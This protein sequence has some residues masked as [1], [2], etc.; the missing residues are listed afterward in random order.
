MPIA[1]WRI[2]ACAFEHKVVLRGDFGAP[3]ILDD[4]NLMRLDDDRGARPRR[5]RAKAG[6][7]YR[8]WRRAIGRANKIACVRVGGRKRVAGDRAAPARRT[9]CRRR[10]PRPTPLPPPGPWVSWMNPNRDLWAASKADFIFAS[11]RPELRTPACIAVSPSDA[12]CSLPRLRGRGCGGGGGMI[13]K[14]SRAR[15]RPVPPPQAGEG[16]LEPRGRLHG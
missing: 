2:S 14:I 7:A 1:L 5:G 16:T 10:W 6:C 8:P 9:S 11:E 15:A 12:A 3:A 13:A 4:D